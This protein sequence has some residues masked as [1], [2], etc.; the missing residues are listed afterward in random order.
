MNEG[1]AGSD[2]DIIR[3]RYHPAYVMDWGGATVEFIP[4]GA[5]V[6]DPTSFDI[7]I[8]SG[9]FEIRRELED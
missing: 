5:A 3:R 6:K 9:D 2:V 7:V 4:G 8:H 1:E